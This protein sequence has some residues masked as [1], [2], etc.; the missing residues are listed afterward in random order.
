MDGRVDR[1]WYLP[2]GWRDISKPRNVQ[3]YLG[4]RSS[5]ENSTLWPDSREQPDPWKTIRNSPCIFLSRS[6]L[7]FGHS[8]L[9]IPYDGD[10]EQDLFRLAS[11][12]IC[13]AIS[14][15][16]AMFSDD[17]PPHQE[18]IFEPLAKMTLTGGHYVRTLVL[19]ASANESSNEYKVHLVPYFKSHKELC[20][21]R[22]HSLHTV[23]PD[24]E[25][26]LLGWIGEREDIVDKWEVDPNPVQST[27]DHIANE[28]L[29]MSELAKRLHVSWREA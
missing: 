15:F 6:P 29:K 14:T 9:L 25:G 13:K 21:K 16:S 12:I 2:R 1:L 27:L 28:H 20:R 22:F 5:L 8:Q 11:E 18:E 26:G 17:K 4:G 24:K 19:R 3:D 7:T 10:S 23:T